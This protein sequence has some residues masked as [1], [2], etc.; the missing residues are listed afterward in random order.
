MNTKIAYLKSHST[1][2]I[3]HIVQIIAFII[4]NYVILELIFLVNLLSFEGLVKMLPILNSPRN[5]L[6][7]GAGIVEYIFFFL[8]E[9][10]FPFLLLGIYFSNSIL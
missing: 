2:I 7:N 10:V 9:G 3:R 8:A 6:S 5:A 4:I 1:S